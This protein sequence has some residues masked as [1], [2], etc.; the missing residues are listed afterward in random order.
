MSAEISTQNNAGVA[1]TGGKM[2]REEEGDDDDE[3][4]W[5]DDEDDDENDDDYYSKKF[6][7]DF[8]DIYGPK[9]LIN[10]VGK[11]IKLI[12]N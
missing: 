9:Y 12:S 4:V 5:E 2:S 10:T 1:S 11:F 8:A 7:S 3:E 6:E